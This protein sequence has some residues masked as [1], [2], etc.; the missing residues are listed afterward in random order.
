[1]LD[2]NFAADLGTV[3]TMSVNGGSKYSPKSA[4]GTS[5]GTMKGKSAP[6]KKNGYYGY[7]N[8]PDDDNIEMTTNFGP[9]DKP[10]KGKRG[11]K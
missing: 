1:M 8:M 6:A 2:K 4:G 7:K 3:A 11:K 10:T 5:A 9:D